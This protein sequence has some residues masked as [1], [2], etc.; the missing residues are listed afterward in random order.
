MFT[1]V[2]GRFAAVEGTV[3]VQGDTP[4][5]ASVTAT[6]HA[7]GIETGTE[8]R[9]QHLRSADFLDAEHY[10]DVTFASTRINGTKDRFTI[11]G[12]LTIRGTT[13]AVTLDAVFEG[14]GT[15]PWG[16]QRMGFRADG[17]IDRREF[18]LVWNQA[19]EAGGLLVSNEIKIHIDAQLVRV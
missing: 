17:T 2:K 14:A 8:Q 11:T 10:P 4:D 15:D 6:M 9:D 3:A 5:T 16:G 18:G 1:T 7:A 19:L 13:R 12:D